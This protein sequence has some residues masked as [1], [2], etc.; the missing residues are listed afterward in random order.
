MWVVVRSYGRAQ[1]NGFVV[2][3]CDLSP[4]ICE[5]VI[6]VYGLA[7]HCGPLS[8]LCGEGQFDVVVMNHVLEHVND[9]VAF[10]SDVCRLLAPGGV[11]HIAVPNVGCWEAVLAGWTSYEPYHLS[12]FTPVTLYETIS[13]AELE[14]EQKVTHESFS[15]WFLAVLRTLLGVNRGGLTIQAN[16]RFRSEVA[17]RSRSV[18]SEH[19]YRLAMICMGGGLWPLRMIQAKLGYGDEAICIARKPGMIWKS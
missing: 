3:G 11:A 19:V 7:M 10:L 16:A 8:G 1:A 17:R 13:A 15:G 9:P 2:T 5:R 6:R 18:L 12:Y 14:I 4:A